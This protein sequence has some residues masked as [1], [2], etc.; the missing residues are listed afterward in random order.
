M[1]GISAKYDKGLLRNVVPKRVKKKFYKQLS[2]KVLQERA[3][4]V[5]SITILFL[6]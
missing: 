1:N 3:L 5:D 2:S 4:F 6:F